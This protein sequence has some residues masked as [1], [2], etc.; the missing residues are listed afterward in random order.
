MLLAPRLSANSKF[1]FNDND[2]LCAEQG[3]AVVAWRRHYGRA[4]R[5]ELQ[6]DAVT[7]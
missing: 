3:I 7:V 4:Q 5:H 1:D 6:Q 2:G